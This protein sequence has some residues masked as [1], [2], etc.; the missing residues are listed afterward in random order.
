MSKSGHHSGDGGPGIKNNVS[1][2]KDGLV[3]SV[4]TGVSMNPIIIFCDSIFSNGCSLFPKEPLKVE[5]AR[6]V[7]LSLV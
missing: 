6:G 1:W 7:S 4:C 3:S 5:G 2:F